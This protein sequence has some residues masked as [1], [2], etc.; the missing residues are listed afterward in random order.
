MGWCF[1]P[2]KEEEVATVLTRELLYIYGGCCSAAGRCGPM[3]GSDTL[4]LIADI[5]R[6][7]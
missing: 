2:D 4:L 6:E 5:M 3:E 7:S 1:R